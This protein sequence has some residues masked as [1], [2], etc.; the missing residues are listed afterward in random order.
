MAALASA[1]Q[2]F[3]VLSGL[4]HAT[5]FAPTLRPGLQSCAASQLCGKGFDP[6]FP[7]TLLCD[8]D[9]LALTPRCDN[10]FHDE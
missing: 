8:A 3:F 1:P 9:S 2:L 7:E 4:A 6:I 10:Q 5:L